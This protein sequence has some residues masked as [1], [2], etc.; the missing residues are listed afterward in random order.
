MGVGADRLPPGGEVCR[1]AKADIGETELVI[2]AGNTKTLRT[3]AVPIIPPLRPW[4]KFLPLAISFEGVKSGF[5]RARV[6]AGVPGVQFRDL[7]RSCGTLLIQAEVPLNVVS[8]ILGHSSTTVTERAY[9][10][11][12]SKQLHKGLGA[13]TELHRGLHQKLKKQRRQV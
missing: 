11:L 2:Q 1:S 12:A 13:L 4:L 10:H 8:K 5:A 9:A 6:A 3:R 7:R